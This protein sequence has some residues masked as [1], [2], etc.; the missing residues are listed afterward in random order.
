MGAVSEEQPNNGMNL[1]KKKELEAV[2]IE[3]TKVKL[4]GQRQEF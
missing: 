3:Q 2:S 1:K 4:E